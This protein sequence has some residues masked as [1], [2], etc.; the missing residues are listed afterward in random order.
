[1]ILK[2]GQIHNGVGR[3]WNGD[4]RIENGII[5]ELG[6]N[7]NGSPA[8]DLEGRNLYPG[9]IDPLTVWGINGSSSEVKDSS[10]DNEELSEPLLPELDILYAVNG[11]AIAAQQ[12]PAY[13]ITACGIA[14]TASNLIGG[15]MAVFYTDG[16]INAL[17]SLAKQQAA[18][19]CSV[20]SRVKQFFGGRGLSP[21]TKMGTFHMLEQ[22]LR[23]ARDSDSLSGNDKL[24][25]LRQALDRKTP[26][27]VY[28]DTAQDRQLVYEIMQPY[29]VPLTFL[30]CD[31]LRSQEA[32]FAD[33]QV[34]MVC[35]YDGINFCHVRSRLNPG[36]LCTYSQQGVRLMASGT[37]GKS[38][39]RENYLWSA[40]ELMRGIHEE[41]TVVQMMTSIPAQVL[42]IAD[43]TGSIEPGKRADLV[44]WSGNPLRSFQARVFRTLIGGET[45]YKEGDVLRCYY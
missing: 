37:G 22:I 2:N 31:N 3:V 30:S 21:M 23:Q 14:P 43:Q 5:A 36:L 33:P 17:R 25:A 41:E 10:E 19:V 9:F 32:C 1:M 6:T 28:C 20:S 29:D 24:R 8:L 4:I 44:I 7:L 42:G 38:Y 35:G 45:V 11:R 39:G 16:K 15:Q 13:G 12:L 34:S 40:M 18:M 26:F 27:F